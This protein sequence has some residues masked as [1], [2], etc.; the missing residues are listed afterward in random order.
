VS[1][2][3][4]GNENGNSCISIEGMRVAKKERRKMNPTSISGGESSNEN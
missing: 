4:N 3:E 2:E 1:R